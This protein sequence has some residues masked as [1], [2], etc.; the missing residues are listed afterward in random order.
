VLYVFEK[1]GFKWADTIYRKFALQTVKNLNW[2]LKLEFIKKN[3][4]DVEQKYHC[5]VL[6]AERTG[7]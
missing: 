5:P 7:L 6:M 1:L 3:S 4:P 2:K